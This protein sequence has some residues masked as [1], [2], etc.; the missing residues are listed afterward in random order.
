MAREVTRRQLLGQAGTAAAGLA[1]LGVAGCAAHSSAATPGVGVLPDASVVGGYHRFITRPDLKPPVINLARKIKGSQATSIF[2]NAPVSGP[3][4]GGGMILDPDGNLVWMGPDVVGAH[5]L[6]FNTQTYQGRPVLTWWE[7]VETHGW[8]QGVLVVADTTYQRKHTLHAV[9]K[10]GTKVN[11]DHHEFNLTDKDTALATVYWPHTANLSS[12]SGPE[13]GSIVSGVFEEMDIATGKM[14]FRWDSL[15][16][17]AIDDTYQ[18]V[19]Y[20]GQHFGVPNNPFDYFHINS[21]AYTDNDENILVSSRNTWCVYKISRKTG[22]IIWRLGGKH[23]DFELGPGARF[24]WQHHVRPHPGG[25]MTVF[26]NGAAPAE[27]RQSRALILEVNEKTM[28]V[29]LKHQYTHPNKALLASAMGSCQLLPNGN[30]MVGWGT[31]PYFSEFSQDGKLLVAGQMTRGNPSY[32]VFAADWSGEPTDKPVV[33]AQKRKSGGKATIYVSWNGATEVRSWGVLAGK[34]RS[35]LSSVG[36][37]HKSGFETA[38]AVQDR[39]PYFAVQA[40]DAK[41]HVLAT[42]HTVKIS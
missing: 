20:E 40:L 26:D 41:G 23:S 36:S 22:N 9:G 4:R 24:Y 5:K 29:T 11:F 13:N 21:L 31:N 30:V 35:S 16:H 25:L 1:G 42:S 8:G 17:V 7:G 28:K 18:P 3:G 38:M 33:V 37:A 15:D 19:F 32:R 2:M 34:T 14:L 39:G 27:E 6:D 10:P 12:I